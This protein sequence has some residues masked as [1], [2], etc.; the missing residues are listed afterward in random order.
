LAVISAAFRVIDSPI[1][2]SS[3]KWEA[4][5]YDRYRMMDSLEARYELIG[6]TRAEVLRL[7]GT[8]S[9]TPIDA[10]DYGAVDRETGRY[11]EYHQL[12]YVIGGGIDAQLF[13]IM[14]DGAGTA[15]LA[16]RLVRH[17]G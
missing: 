5:V 3:E 2:F 10:T 16:V 15:A 9:V 1:E 14:F 4:R 12:E 8:T 13:T 11:M 7:L 17:E 6:M